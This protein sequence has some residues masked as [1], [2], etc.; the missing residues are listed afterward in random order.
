MDEVWL[1]GNHSFADCVAK[2]GTQPWCRPML[3]NNGSNK[4][5]I[6][7]GRYLGEATSYQNSSKARQDFVANDTYTNGKTIFTTI[8]GIN[9]SGKSTYLKQIATIVI[10]A[11]CGGYVP[12]EFA[13]IPVR[14]WLCTRIGNTDDQGELS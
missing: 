1:H 2:K 8:T 10:L 5:V 11:H 12:A 4:I 13:C 3:T 7:N 14:D 9:G 6:R